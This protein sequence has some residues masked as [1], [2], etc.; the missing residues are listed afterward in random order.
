M[1][2]FDIEGNPTLRRR[3]RVRLINQRKKQQQQQQQLQEEPAARAGRDI[4]DRRVGKEEAANT[5]LKFVAV[6]FVVAFF[7]YFVLRHV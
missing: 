3:D 6:L 7:T 2:S 1:P 4:S 5:P